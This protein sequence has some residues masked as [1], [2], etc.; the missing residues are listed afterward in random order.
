M[1][2][3]RNLTEHLRIKAETYYQVLAKAPVE[4][5]L[6]S[7]SALN[8]GSFLGIADADSLV[9]KGR[10]YNYGLELTAE[11]FFN[12][13]F[14]FLVTTSLF[15]SKYKGSD[16]VTRNTAFNTNYVFNALAGKEFKVGSRGNTLAFNIKFTTVGG[17]YFTPINLEASRREGN[18]VYYEDKA[19]TDKQSAYLRADMKI[20]YRKEYRK[21]T[22]ELAIDLQNFTNHQNIFSRYYDSR[23]GKIV[24][25]YQQSFFPIP[26]IRYT[27]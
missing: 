24:T 1:G 12:H 17:R 3:D 15:E 9:N 11:R 18:T 26:M 19:F 22:L 14:Y 6:S 20:A 23:T 5:R 16:G 7:Y 21:S 13:G 10:G 8:A 27:F 25:G 4:Q 2:Y